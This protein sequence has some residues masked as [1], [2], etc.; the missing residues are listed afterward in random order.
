MSSE[1]RSFEL[2][3][4]FLKDGLEL[5]E[6]NDAIWVVVVCIHNLINLFGSNAMTQSLE[7][8]E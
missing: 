5:L 4:L 6:V 3:F 8:V 2:V 1:L 7:S